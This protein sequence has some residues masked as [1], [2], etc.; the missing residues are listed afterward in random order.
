MGK[1]CH[2]DNKMYEKRKTTEEI[3]VS[4]Q[5]NIETQISL[6]NWVNPFIIYEPGDTSGL[7]KILLAETTFSPLCYQ[8]T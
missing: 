7:G 8:I 3:K 5:E 6:N 2:A 4:N 1:M